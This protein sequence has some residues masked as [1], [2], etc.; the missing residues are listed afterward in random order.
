VVKPRRNVLG[1]DGDV[2]P[3]DSTPD[4]AVLD[5]AWGEEEAESALDDLDAGWDL[6]EQR[7]AAADV[8]VGLDAGARRRAAGERAAARKEK[9]RAKK[10]AAQEKRK[11]HSESI[12]QKQ[13][14]PKRQRATPS[15]HPGPG[16]ERGASPTVEDELEA[17]KPPL[18]RPLQRSAVASKKK[19]V[20]RR[21]NVR[22]LLFLVAFAVATGALVFSLSRR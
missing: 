8:A 12:R 9:L 4:L 22:V 11:A 20:R 5:S 14:K 21:N 10:V 3:V 2:G 18:E 13:K 17:A 7:A 6:E 16:P 15:R 1:T 19:A